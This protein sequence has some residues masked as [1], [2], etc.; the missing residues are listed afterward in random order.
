MEWDAC[1]NVS[2][3]RSK[4]KLIMEKKKMQDIALHA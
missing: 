1:R 3:L 4:W 2:E